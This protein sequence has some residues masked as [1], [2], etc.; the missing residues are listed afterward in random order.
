VLTRGFMLDTSAINR[1]HDGLGCEWSLRGPL[2][3]TDIQLQ[4]I[5]QTRN[6]ERRDSLLGAFLS[7]R[8]TIIRPSGLSFVPEYFGF[9]SYC[10]ASFTLY[11]EDYPRPVGRMMPYIAAALGS[12]VEK[13]FR[14]ALIA[15]ATLVSELT[16]VTADRKLAKV[17]GSFGAR[18]EEIA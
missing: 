8:P 3:V 11:D 5:A 13:Q 10:D 16:L 4:E 12:H 1:I 18:V 15:E 17:A 7:L 2:Y 6:P 9:S 14:D